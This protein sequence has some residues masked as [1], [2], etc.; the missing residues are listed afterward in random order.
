V[1]YNG[2]MPRHFKNRLLSP[3]DMDEPWA[4]S[5]LDSIARWALQRRGIRERDI[6]DGATYV[7]GRMRG[8]AGKWRPGGLSFGN[9]LM[10]IACRSAITFWRNTTDNGR[11][12][13]FCDCPADSLDFFLESQPDPG[14]SPS[15]EC[16]S[17]DA[18]EAVR[19]F[20][21]AWLTP[22]EKQCI[23]LVLSGKSYRASAALTG[24]TS[25][26]LACGAKAIDNALHRIKSKAQRALRGELPRGKGGWPRWP[27]KKR[28]MPVVADTSVRV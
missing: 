26:G 4:A 12:V 3:S 8:N 16:Q 13:V 14:R 7:T 1:L 19:G 6:E 11:L 2:G 17:R 18:E 25:W 20:F 28:A 9:F 15:E 27:R 10:L 21:D 5:G 24:P 22:F 23:L